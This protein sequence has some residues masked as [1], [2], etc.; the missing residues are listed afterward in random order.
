[1]DQP[2][3]EL[4]LALGVLE[5]Q[6]WFSQRS[7]ET[8]SVL[9]PI[10]KLRHFA[11][12]ESVYLAGD[13][14]NGA[15]GLVCGSLNISFPRNDGED[16][17]VHRAGS[18]FWLGDLALLSRKRRLV[19]V[20]AAEPTIMVQLPARELGR[21]LRDDPRLY[22]DFYALTYENFQ[23]ALQ[24]IANLTI[25]SAEKRVA[26]RLVLEVEAR[27]DSDGWISMSQPELAKLLAISLPTLQRVMRRLT[28]AGLVRKS[29]AK[30]QVIDR[31]A[32][33]HI[34]RG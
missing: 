21:L 30:I 4:G 15:F 10:A 29:Y 34:C 19:S 11:K 3:T 27:G 5:A 31:Q 26:D 12:D 24:I 16:Y 28:A 13:P 22:A 23:T 6:G 32:L 7:R 18:G 33:A 8:R 17:T 1:M 14:P 25:T 9:R 2:I 20:R